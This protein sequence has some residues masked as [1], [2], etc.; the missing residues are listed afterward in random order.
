MIF[1]TYWF[2]IFLISF[3]LLFNYTPW[4]IGKSCLLAIG[5]T[6]FYFHFA[7]PAGILPIIIMGGVTYILGLSNNQT[8]FKLGI[9]L[10]VLA[11]IFYK[12]TLFLASAIN[13]LFPI[14]YKIPTSPFASIIAPLAISFFAFEFIHYLYDV[15]RGVKPIKNPLNFFHFAMF[16]P[17]IAAGPIKRF[18]SFMPQLDKALRAKRLKLADLQYGVLRF[19]IGFIKK[20]AA[21]SLS[22]FIAG[23]C[24]GAAFFD[25]TLIQRWEIFVA[26]AFRIYLDFSG[27]SDM[28][29]GTARMMGIKIPENFNWPYLSS[30]LTQFWRRWHISLS[31]WIRDYLYIP[32]GGN[33][34]GPIKHAVNLLIVFLVCGLWHGASWNFI[35]WGGFHGLGLVLEG[36]L[37]SKSY[38]SFEVSQ[39][40]GP[41]KYVKLVFG[42]VM[43]TIF[44][45]LGWLLFFYP[46]QQALNMALS[47][48][49]ISPLVK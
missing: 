30:S 7:G 8:L 3:L 45:W 44:V 35:A 17:T 33:K 39:N 41:T 6:V 31:S 38:T 48:L 46:P 26:L 9:A 37:I 24:V 25:C 49:N 36:L 18:E 2:L 20:I 29:I 15:K 4:Q 1:S 32:L 28:A 23:Q 5:S 12:Y 10:S 27:Y 42:W 14:L 22:I 40:G 21:D 13:D 47:L 16:F 19:V 34:V 11:L 43:T